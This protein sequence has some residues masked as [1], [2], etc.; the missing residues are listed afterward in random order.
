MI[1]STRSRL[2]QVREK[3]RVPVAFGRE[4]GRVRKRGRNGEKE[5]RSA[6][7]KEKKRTKTMKKKKKEKKDAL[8]RRVGG[9]E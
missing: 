5:R 2:S 6:V 3:R 4:W 7:K 1:A 9:G 8:H